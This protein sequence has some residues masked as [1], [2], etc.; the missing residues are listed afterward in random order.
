MAL[1]HILESLSLN[2]IEKLLSTASSFGEKQLL[3][4]GDMQEEVVRLQQNL[5]KIKEFFTEIENEGSS[6]DQNKSLQSWLWQFRDAVEEAEDVLDELEYNEIEKKVQ[7]EDDMVNGM[8]SRYKRKFTDFIAGPFKDVTFK[9]LKEAVK[10]LDNVAAG[11][12]NFLLLAHGM[13]RGNGKHQEQWKLQRYC[14]TSAF[15]TER[16]VFGREKEKMQV[17]NWLKKPD[18]NKSTDAISAFTVVGLGGMGKTTLA[19]IVYDDERVRENFELL[20]WVHVS[21]KFDTITIIKRILEAANMHTWSEKL[22]ELQKTLKEKLESK[23]FFLILDDVWNDSDGS[24]WEKLIEPLK[25]GKKGSKIFVT[26]RMQSVA[27]MVS[28]QTNQEAEWLKLD[29]LEEKDYL[30][31]FNSHAFASV[32]PE[33]YKDLQLIGNQIAKKLGGCPLTAKVMGGQLNWYM[34]EYYW[35]KILKEDIINIDQGENGIMSILKLSY[36]HLPICLQLCFRY[37]A[38]FPENYVF[39]KDELI[40][41]WLNSGLIH[42]GD[43]SL[44]KWD[45][46]ILVIS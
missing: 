7:V 38:I 1:N 5:A 6:I 34:D 3:P 21:N 44:R 26:T 45:V 15:S 42:N 19:Q 11:K 16:K 30:L 28:K 41:M 10:K 29:G 17:I 8:F 39:D 32:D 20:M 2:V 12:D 25:F 46:N 36:S 33:K 22:E 23:R 9:R 37:C 14:E 31:L 4:G 40:Y 43:Q 35:E 18:S 24:E 13:N 27:E